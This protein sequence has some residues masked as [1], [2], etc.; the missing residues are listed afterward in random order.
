MKIKET[1]ETFLHH[2]TIHL[3][4]TLLESDLDSY[5]SLE[6]LTNIVATEYLK[7]G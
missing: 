6:L 3:L 7:H 5:F 1:L 4:Y 2:S